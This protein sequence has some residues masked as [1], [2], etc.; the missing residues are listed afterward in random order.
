M[1]HIKNF[2]RNNGLS[3]D[4]IIG[5]LTFN[6]MK[7]AWKLSGIELAHF[8]GQGHHESGGFKHDTENLNYS[9]QGLL[10]VFPKYFNE[11]KAE[12][13]ARKPEKIAN[14]VYANRMGNGDEKSG[15]GWKFRGRGIMGLTGFNNYERL[16]QKIRDC[17][18]LARPEKVAD[19]YFFDSGLFFFN[20]NNLWII[21]KDLKRDTIK[22]LTRQVNG[23][24]NGLEDRINKT[25]YYSK[26]I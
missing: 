9:K 24:Y 12:Q 18:I 7:E 26:F 16:A 17:S 22:K 14:L 2:Q 13:Y 20:E 15:D 19:K 1:E 3:A 11:A 21:C 10:N 5:K 25:L 6:K 4:G 8:L 23:G